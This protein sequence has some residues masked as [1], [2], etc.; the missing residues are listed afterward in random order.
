MYA[1]GATRALKF[2]SSVTLGGVGASIVGISSMAAG[3][4]PLPLLLLLFL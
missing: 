1:N 4:S 2:A 3:E